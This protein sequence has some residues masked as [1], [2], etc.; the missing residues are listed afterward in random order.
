[1]ANYYKCLIKTAYSL[2]HISINQSNL[3]K[4][5]YSFL[6]ASLQKVTHS[7]K[8]ENEFYNFFLSNNKIYSEYFLVV[9]R[10]SQR[11]H[12]PI[13][14]LSKIERK[15]IRL[16]QESV[17]EID[18]GQSQPLFLSAILYEQIKE[19]DFTSLI[20]QGGDI[21]TYFQKTADLK[22]REQAKELFFRILFS[23]PNNTLE[24]YFPNGSWIKWI[25]RYKR[26]VIPENR[27]TYQKP[28]SNLAWLL[29]SKE[30]RVMK[31][32]WEE[33]TFHKIHFLTVHDALLVA[34]SKAVI[35]EYLFQT[36]LKR[37][38]K[39]FQLNK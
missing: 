39:T 32:V 12:T 29:Q 24:Q 14:T 26:K 22:D 18:L 27:H 21:Y 19:N 8:T 6:L 11:I 4:E 37:H 34:K 35:A 16:N 2:Q 33:L 20:E 7:K 38:F 13:T 23:K 31:E 3:K 1:M 30:V 9:D 25:N 10:F 28:H 36:V 15:N 17:T 5:L